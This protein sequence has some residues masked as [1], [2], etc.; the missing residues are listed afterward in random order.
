MKELPAART[1]LDAR[2]VITLLAI[3]TI[4]GVFWLGS[5]YP[6]LQSK[7]GADPDEAL[8]TPLGFESHWPE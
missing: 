1:R 2:V 6:S 3:A 5:R 8:S 7:A 4:C